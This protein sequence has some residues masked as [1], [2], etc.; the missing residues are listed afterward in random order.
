MSYSP[1]L[2]ESCSWWNLVKFFQIGATT[3]IYIAWGL[4]PCCY[5]TFVAN[6]NWIWCIQILREKW[7]LLLS[8]SHCVRLQFLAFSAGCSRRKHEIFFMLSNN[9]R[10]ITATA[11]K[12]VWDFSTA[13]VGLEKEQQV[14]FIRELCCSSLFSSWQDFWSNKL[15]CMWVSLLN[16]EFLMFHSCMICSI[17]FSNVGKGGLSKGCFC[18]SPVLVEPAEFVNLDT[19]PSPD[20]WNSGEENPVLSHWTRA[21]FFSREQKSRGADHA[22]QA[23][24]YCSGCVEK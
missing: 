9:T 10:K 4:V 17:G 1:A 19:M 7:E 22:H 18:A 3:L 21:G 13:E 24:K 2:R 23:S 20:S 16:V 15:T 14:I 6:A 11:S 5:V 12:Q 8:E